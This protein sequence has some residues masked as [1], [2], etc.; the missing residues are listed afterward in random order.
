[1]FLHFSIL[2][3][4]DDSV[5]SSTTTTVAFLCDRIIITKLQQ[6]FTMKQ[7]R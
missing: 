7:M 1:M 5:Q 4:W 2:Q 3:A 6:F